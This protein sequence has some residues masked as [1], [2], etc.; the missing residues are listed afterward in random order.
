M[1]KR[2][3]TTTMPSEKVSPSSPSSSGIGSTGPPRVTTEPT[4]VTS[5]S[6]PNAKMPAAPR[7]V[8]SMLEK[9]R[10]FTP[11]AAPKTPS[12]RSPLVVTRPKFITLSPG[13]TTVSASSSTPEVE[14]VEKLNLTGVLAV[15]AATAASPLGAPRSAGSGAVR[16]LD[17][18]AEVAAVCRTERIDLGGEDV[19]VESFLRAARRAL[20]EELV[21]AS[22]VNRFFRGPECCDPASSVA[23]PL[24]S[25]RPSVS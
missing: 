5:T 21:S 20:S 18:A 4:F 23:R 3:P 14:I 25:A 9:L 1:W 19:R 13:V 7:P 6:L 12:A 22:A 24:R 16:K 8:V 11:S 17:G 2:S 15:N 10:I